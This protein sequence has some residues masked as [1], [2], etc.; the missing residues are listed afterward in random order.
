MRRLLAVFALVLLGL[1]GPAQAAQPYDK[2]AFMK[3]Q[4]MGEPILLHVTAP[5]CPTCRA[6]EKTV[7]MLEKENPRL[8]VFKVDFDSQKDVLKELGA[9]TQST[10]ITFAKGKETGRTVG[11]TDPAKIRDLAGKAM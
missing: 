4:E 3:A 7:Q 11:V 8:K 2:A 1:T 6:Q 9:D 5:W 10:L